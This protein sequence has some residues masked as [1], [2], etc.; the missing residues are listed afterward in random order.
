MSAAWYDTV[1]G[2]GRK[3][4]SLGG[5]RDLIAARAEAYYKR[6]E[7]LH[8]Y[9]IQG[10][11]V[12]DSC[13]NFGVLVNK[14]NLK[15]SPIVD[16][17][18]LSKVLD[19]TFSWRLDVDLPSEDFVCRLCNRKWTVDN[20]DDFLITV[21]KVEEGKFTEVHAHKKCAILMRSCAELSMFRNTFSLAGFE[22][23]FF[24]PIKNGY[25]I[26]EDGESLS[27]TPWYTV[28]TLIG[29]ITIGWRKRVIH[30]DWPELIDESASNETT[31]NFAEEVFKDEDVTKGINMI[32]AWSYDKAAEYLRKVRER[33]A[34]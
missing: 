18:E 17:D 12:M 34:A 2:I 33:F 32:H 23:A 28:G 8:K 14:H 9:I 10:K 31:V 29:D 7:R 1:E 22:F 13:G 25:L 30:I 26:N 20:A 3:M 11:W 19:H 5:L 27:A 15:L 16:M 24:K 21:Q 4:T 6:G